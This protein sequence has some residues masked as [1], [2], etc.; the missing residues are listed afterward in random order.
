MVV[1]HLLGCCKG[2]A[3]L[4]FPLVPKF[5]LGTPPVPREISFGGDLKDSYSAGIGHE[6][7][8]ASAFPSETWERGGEGNVARR[9]T[10]TSE[11]LHRR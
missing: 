8:S 7:A 1:S 3:D 5:H 11:R 4:L 6:I 10:A 9:S 2:A